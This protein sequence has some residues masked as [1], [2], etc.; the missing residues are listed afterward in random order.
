M[1][2]HT[3]ETVQKLF[4]TEK[5]KDTWSEIMK[6]KPKVDILPSV[7]E[8]IHSEMVNIPMV[9]DTELQALNDQLIKISQTD[10]K[11]DER[12]AKK[13]SEEGEKSASEG[14]KDA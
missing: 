11:D 6:F 9:H 13:T 5:D 12:G 2:T 7:S 1:K 10:D 4:L 14:Q 3:D 8:Q